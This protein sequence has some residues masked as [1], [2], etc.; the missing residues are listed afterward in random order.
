MTEDK[1]EYLLKKMKFKELLD[2][3]KS[4]D[5][6]IKKKKKSA[7]VKALM[8][9]VSDD[10]MREFFA[11]LRGTSSDIASHELVP[12][13]EI[14]KKKDVEA[15]LKN[16]HSTEGDLPRIFDTDPMCLKI[17]AKPGDVIKV[18]RPSKTAG[19]AYYYRLV[20]RNI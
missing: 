15:V 9:S 4:K 14:M 7:V 16:F 1:P 12:K 5:I 11:E 2:L 17:G 8:E 19:E 10:E 3:A 20:V 18:T 13:H 6:D